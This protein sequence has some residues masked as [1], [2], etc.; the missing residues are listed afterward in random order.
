MESL[1]RKVRWTILG[2]NNQLNSIQHCPRVDVKL[3][4]GPRPRHDLGPGESSLLTLRRDEPTAADTPSFDSR[5][6]VYTP[7]QQAPS[8]DTSADEI[9]DRDTKDDPR[10]GP[11]FLTEWLK[12]VQKNPSFPRLFGK[13][14]V[15]SLLQTAFDLKRE[16]TGDPTWHVDQITHLSGRRPP[17]WD[18][19]SVSWTQTHLRAALILSQPEARDLKAYNETPAKPIFEF[20]EGDLL[21]S[22]VSAYFD[23]INIYAPLLHRPTFEAEL[24]SALHLRDRSF[25]AVLLA[26]CAL[27]ARFSNDPRIFMSGTDGLQSAGWKWFRQVTVMKQLPWASPSLYDLQLHSVSVSPSYPRAF[28]T[29]SIA[30]P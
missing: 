26:V 28:L 7:S 4:L 17:Y 11:T 12:N 27:G 16:H 29:W 9:S 8:V 25:A 23:E 24:A 20:P 15:F 14:G 1:F 3:E 13:S 10:S 21:P 18:V 5:S 19:N 6:S 22:L 30:Y 2:V